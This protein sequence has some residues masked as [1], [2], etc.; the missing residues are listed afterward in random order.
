M[1]VTWSEVRYLCS[2]LL[3]LLLLVEGGGAGRGLGAACQLHS[4][5]EVTFLLRNIPSLGTFS[6]NVLPRI[7]TQTFFLSPITGD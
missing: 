7:L 4:G 3:L 1:L 5:S 6:A 2:L